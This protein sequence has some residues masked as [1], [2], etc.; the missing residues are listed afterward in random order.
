MTLMNLG[1][2]DH[3]IDLLVHL[4]RVP[5][6]ATTTLGDRLRIDRKARP[7][8]ETGGPDTTIGNSSVN[9]SS[10]L[11]QLDSLVTF[12]TAATMNDAGSQ[13]TEGSIDWLTRKFL[14]MGFK[15]KLHRVQSP[16]QLEFL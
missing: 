13:Y 10:W 14:E 7:M 11:F 5:Y 8:R 6:V 12:A 15:I 4:S 1:V 2:P 16:L 9:V 3:V